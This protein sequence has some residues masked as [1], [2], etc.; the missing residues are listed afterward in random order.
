MMT[1]VENTMALVYVENVFN[2]MSFIVSLIYGA[3]MV[4]N[5]SVM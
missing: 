5:D 1:E 3:L 2:K 4:L